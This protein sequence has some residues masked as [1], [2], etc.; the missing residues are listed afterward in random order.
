MLSYAC[1]I[2]LPDPGALYSI[3]VVALSRRLIDFEIHDV[4]EVLRGAAERAAQLPSDET[5][6]LDSDGPP[7]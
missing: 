6:L 5:M 4:I 2:H 7:D 3:G 1:P